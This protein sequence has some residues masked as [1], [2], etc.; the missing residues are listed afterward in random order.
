MKRLFIVMM[1]AA[2]ALFLTAAASARQGDPPAKGPAHHY[3]GSGHLT[4]T[5]EATHPT[6]SIDFATD[7]AWIAAGH[8]NGKWIAGTCPE[9]P[10]V[11]HDY[12]LTLRVNGGL[13]A[14]IPDGG[15]VM[16]SGAYT[17]NGDPVSG[18]SVSLTVYGGYMCTGSPVFGP[19]SY[20]TTDS[21]GLFSA[22]SGATSTGQYSAQVN[23][24]ST[25]SNC[26]N[27]GVGKVT[28]PPAASVT[29]PP[30]ENNVFLCY[31]AFQTT[32]GV[33]NVKE[34]PGLIAQGYWHPYAVAGNVEGGT[35]I[36]TYHL[37]CN[38]ATGQ[39][40]GQQF[41]ALDGYLTGIDQFTGVSGVIGWYPVVP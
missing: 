20:F 28:P 19:T 35:N 39:A 22:L 12:V 30:Q 21:G 6:S 36:G 3:T 5:Y 18:S 17:D 31:S 14:V 33:W 7:A 15:T 32:P 24:G 16:Y 25:E 4:C 26:V 37:T 10:P 11:I 13:S 23:V 2:A 9:A 27:V 29:L 38:L 34:A 41:A 8:V 40:A 1:V